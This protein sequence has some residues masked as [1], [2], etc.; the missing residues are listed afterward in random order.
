MYRNVSGT[1]R[2]LRIVLAASAGVA[3]YLFDDTVSDTPL[4]LT[5]CQSAII[6]PL[7]TQAGGHILMAFGGAFVAEFVS[8][9]NAVSF[10]ISMQ[11]AFE[12]H[13]DTVPEDRRLI[14]RVGI[15]LWD[16]AAGSKEISDECVNVAIGLQAIAKPGGILITETVFQHARHHL[17]FDFEDAGKHR[18]TETAGLIPTYRVANGTSPQSNGLRGDHFQ[19]SLVVLP[20]VNMSGDPEQ[21]YLSDGITD[22]I[23]ARLS[24]ISVLYV[25]SRDVAFSYQG[26]T[27]VFSQL[28]LKLGVQYLLRGSVKKLGDRLLINVTLIDGHTQAQIWAK[29]YTF[30]FHGIFELQSFISGD[31]ADALH[32]KVLPKERDTL[33]RRSTYSSESYR[34]YLMG[35]SYF[36]LSHTRRSLS[37]ARQMFQRALEIDPHYAAAHAGIA[38][39]CAHLIEAG[40]FSVTT[41][42]ILDHSER[43]LAI[44]SSLAEAH[45]SK[46]LALHTTGHYEEAEGCFKRAITLQ[47]DLFEAHYFYG[48]NCF[49]LGQFSEASD[50]FGQAAKLKRSDFRSLGIQSMC[51]QSLS[52]L[53][54]ARTAAWSALGRVE[55]TITN[56]P[57][58][59]DALSFGAGILAF[60]GEYDR[61]RAWAERATIIDP[62]DFYTQY[63]VACAYAILGAKEEAMDRLERIM[64]P[65]APRSQHE[66]MMHDSD[67]GSGPIKFLA[68]QLTF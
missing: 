28:A 36:N 39:C 24:K 55:A 41:S 3:P 65:P 57:D 35:R 7:I 59:V 38:D 21:N 26:S 64:M 18:L 17:S 53:S 61:T 45:A 58:N 67:L 16:T 11:Q 30:E 25:V 5:E 27:E 63:N 47:P 54:E 52:Q 19:S 42:E 8:V 37:L 46:G 2:R 4:E 60:L 66:F 43:A 32:L 12:A 62:D 68:D 13:N 51:F 15:D 20:F 6:E 34:F 29:P 9:V 1:E 10:A 23:I 50:L 48:R 49:N 44:D 33:N 40:D 56:R 31:I 22:D 14:F